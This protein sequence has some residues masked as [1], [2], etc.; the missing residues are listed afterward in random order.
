MAHLFIWYTCV[1]RYLVAHSPQ[2]AAALVAPSA[3]ATDATLDFV[4]AKLLPHTCTFVATAAAPD[5]KSRP[6]SL[7]LLETS[8][9]VVESRCLPPRVGSS[10]TDAVLFPALYVL[11]GPQGRLPEARA[12]YP[13]ICAFVTQASAHYAGVLKASG[14]LPAQPAGAFSSMKL[15]F[16]CCSDAY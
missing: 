14:W 4:E 5:A 11:F 3:I 16:W 6:E 2:A 10:L 7:A 1:D 12:R 9:A 13:Q 15:C 8:L